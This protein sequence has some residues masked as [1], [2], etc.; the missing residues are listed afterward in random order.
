MNPKGEQIFPLMDWQHLRVGDAMAKSSIRSDETWPLWSWRSSVAS[1][2]RTTRGRHWGGEW[3]AVVRPAVVSSDCQFK[4]DSPGVQLILWVATLLQKH[5]LCVCK[6]TSI[7]LYL[8]QEL[9][10]KHSLT[11]FS[12][13]FLKG[14]GGWGARNRDTGIGAQRFLLGAF[15]SVS[16]PALFSSH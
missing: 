11:L 14:P 9:C 15:K 2:E 1:R 13:P 12:I 8:Q 4:F 3:P 6:P 10:L 7:D 5:F 16:R